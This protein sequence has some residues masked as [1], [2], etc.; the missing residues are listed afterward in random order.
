M[1]EA[2]EPPSRPASPPRVGVVLAA[3]RSER[4]SSITRGGSKA[5]LRLG[6]LSLVEAVAVVMVGA[7][8]FPEIAGS[9][10]D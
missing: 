5:L 3:G 7:A 4:I 6:G 8:N 1:T 10:A 2:P 9:D